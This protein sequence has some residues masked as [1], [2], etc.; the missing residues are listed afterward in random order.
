MPKIQTSKLEIDQSVRVEEITK[1]TVVGIANERES[2]TI[3][4]PK[5]A[6][7]VL[8]ETFRLQ[9]RTKKFAPHVF[10]AAIAEGLRHTPFQSSDIVIDFEYP[11]YEREII[12]IIKQEHPHLEIY[13]T[14]IGK[15]SPAHYAAYGVHLKKRKSD[16]RVDAKR[17]TRILFP[18]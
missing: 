8:R 18:K 6:K 9:G 12:E 10:A 13:F 16:F 1:D 15:K 4:V 2:F 5:R 7:R 11:A 3:I 17:I 14:D